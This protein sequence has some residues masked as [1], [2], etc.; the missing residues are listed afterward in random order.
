MFKV[1]KENS[2]EDGINFSWENPETFYGLL[3]QMIL[4]YI[5]TRTIEESEAT[6]DDQIFS[7]EKKFWKTWVHLKMLTRTPNFNK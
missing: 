4:D 2:K 1:V 3:I 7:N 6:I 5:K